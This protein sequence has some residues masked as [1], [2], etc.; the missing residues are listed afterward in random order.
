[1]QRKRG[2]ESFWGSVLN[3]LELLTMHTLKVRKIPGR[4]RTNYID[5]ESHGVVLRRMNRR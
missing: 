1:M 2:S 3:K 5:E 4:E